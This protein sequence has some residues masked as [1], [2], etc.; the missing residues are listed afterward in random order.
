MQRIRAAFG[1]VLLGIAAIAVVVFFQ[2]AQFFGYCLP[3]EEDL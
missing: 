1:L 2:V 3:E